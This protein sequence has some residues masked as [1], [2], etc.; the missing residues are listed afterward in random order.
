MRTGMHSFISNG[1]RQTGAALVVSMVLLM[2][3]TILAI[4]TMNTASLEVAMAGNRQY[5][6]NAFQLAETGLDRHVATAADPANAGICD[7]PTDVGSQACDRDV[8][9]IDE[10]DGS[11]T[12][13]TTYRRES[14]CPGAN[15]IGYFQSYN[16]EVQSV[17][18]TDNDGAVSQHTLGWYICRNGT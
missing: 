16:F 3:L 18:Q 6:E 4:S 10:M 2:V 1:H 7:I 13:T 11:F 9:V 14:S 5:Q 8:E 17:G 15:T 12:T